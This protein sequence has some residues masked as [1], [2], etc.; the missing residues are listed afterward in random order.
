MWIEIHAVDQGGST[1]F[2]SGGWNAATGELANDPQLK[3]YEVLQGIWDAGT[4]TCR[5]TDAQGRKQFRFALNNCI[6]KDNRIPPEGF[7][8]RTASD[9]IG[10]ELRPVAY[11][12]P[13]TAPGSGVLVNHDV[14]SYTIPVPPGVTA[15]TVTAR[16]HF[17]VASKDYIDFLRNEAVENNQPSE[18]QMCDRS[19]TVGPANKSRGQ[20]LYDL[21][22]SPQFGRSPPVTM[23]TVSVVAGS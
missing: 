15:L 18:N 10:L 17:Q 3:V 19:W 13:E 22:A 2:R 11:T 23:R 4:A 12:Y 14:T 5:T 7:M 6:A 20:F 16:L 21:W 8:P 1:V 9:P